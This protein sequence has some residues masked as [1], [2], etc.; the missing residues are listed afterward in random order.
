MTNGKSQRI[1]VNITPNE[2]LE[3]LQKLTSDDDFRSNLEKNPREILSR[4]H[5]YLT[6]EQIPENFAL[7]SKEEMQKIQKQLIAGE[8]FQI[9]S[10]NAYIAFLAFLAFI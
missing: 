3:F 7:P 9:E 5:I 8:S 10:K 1:G 2:S 4:H 6:P